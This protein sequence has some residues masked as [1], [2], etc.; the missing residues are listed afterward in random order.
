MVKVTNFASAIRAEVR[1]LAAKEIKK[2]LRPLRAVK[3]Q[4]RGLRLTSRADRK[5]LRAV[6]RRYDRLD[7][8][9]GSTGARGRRGGM[10]AEGIRSLRARLGMSRADFAKLVGV[11]AGSIFGWETGRT[12]PRGR[13]M[14][15]VVEV[16]K[17]GVRRARARVATRVAGPKRRVV[18]RRPRRGKAR[19][20]RR[21]AA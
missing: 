11:S 7:R 10:S 17:M 20:A 21:R 6:E 12:V 15:R 13:S 18:S 8:R 16:K 14:G 19:R 5:T 2:A 3:R 4:V 1:R 9:V